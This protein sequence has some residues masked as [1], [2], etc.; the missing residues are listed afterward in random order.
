[1][2]YKRDETWKEVVRRVSE[3]LAKTSI[4][5]SDKLKLDLSAYR[6]VDGNRL[7]R[8]DYDWGCST[9]FGF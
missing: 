9:R 4:P 3:E 7:V 2:E 5:E 1:M 8:S 6:M